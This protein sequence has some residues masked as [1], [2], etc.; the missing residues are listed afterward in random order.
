MN[1]LHLNALGHIFK[2]VKPV[3][4]SRNKVQHPDCFLCS[5]CVFSFTP[6]LDRWTK[7]ILPLK[8]QTF[9]FSSVYSF[10][11]LLSSLHLFCNLGRKPP[12]LSRRPSGL[13]RSQTESHLPLPARDQLAHS[14][15]F[16]Q[17]SLILR[18]LQMF[19]MKDE[20]EGGSESNPINPTGLNCLCS[21][22]L[23]NER[24][25]GKKSVLSG[26]ALVIHCI[27]FLSIVPYVPALNCVLTTA[28]K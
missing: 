8:P 13:Q 11:D 26:A 17:Y 6:D 19:N 3:G 7:I 10:F 22:L 15:L 9:I 20:S 25:S 4:C 5:M 21:D 14:P 16:I 28:W 2:N 18:D 23:R 1:P 24:N 27:F 12:G